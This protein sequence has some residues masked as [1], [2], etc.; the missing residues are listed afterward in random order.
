MWPYNYEPSGLFRFF[1]CY[2]ILYAIMLKACPFFY[3]FLAA[4]LVICRLGEDS[5]YL[6]AVAFHSSLHCLLPPTPPQLSSSRDSSN[7]WVVP[8]LQHLLLCCWGIAE[9]KPACCC[10]YPSWAQLCSSWAGWAL[11]CCPPQKQKKTKQK[12]KK[13][14]RDHS[15]GERG[16]GECHWW[17]GRQSK[18]SKNSPLGKKV[19]GYVFRAYQG[20]V[21]P[22]CSTA[23]SLP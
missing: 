20:R 17:R 13:I 16:R 3:L 12:T 10:C 4:C 9:V 11:E 5:F 15:S 19:L 6:D 21:Q 2:L 8:L 1:S 18:A 23:A 7:Q 14:A 22:C